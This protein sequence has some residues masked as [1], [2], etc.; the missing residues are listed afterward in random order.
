MATLLIFA[1][2]ENVSSVRLHDLGTFLAFYAAFGLSLA[3]VGEW[4]RAIGELLVAIPR[5][6]RLR[7]S[8]A[9]ACCN[10]TA[11]TTAG[12]RP[13]CAGMTNPSARP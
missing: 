5:I 3:A 2:A 4:A 1:L 10:R 9:F 6:E 11:L 7:P 13:F 8:N 12:M